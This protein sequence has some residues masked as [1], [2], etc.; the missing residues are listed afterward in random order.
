LL[1]KGYIPRYI[2]LGLFRINNLIFEDLAVQ[3]AASQ[4]MVAPNDVRSL[5]EMALRHK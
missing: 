1:K 5:S 2:A 3:V 4:I